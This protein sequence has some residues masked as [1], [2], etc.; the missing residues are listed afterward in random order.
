MAITMN[1]K[2]NQISPSE[3]QVESFISKAEGAARNSA[4]ASPLP[5]SVLG[6]VG[7]EVEEG[8]NRKPVIVRVPADLLKLIDKAAKKQGIS[9]SAFIV[10]SM[11]D[12]VNQ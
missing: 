8:A 9:R 2:R 7:I 5:G 1:P 4:V 10:S 3:S 11:A 6:P 12:V